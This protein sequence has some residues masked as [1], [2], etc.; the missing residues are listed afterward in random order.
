MHFYAR[1]R[2]AHAFTLIELLTVIAIVGILAA[3]LIPVVSRVRA[4]ARA[5]EC[6]SNLRQLSSAATLYAQDNRGRLPTNYDGTLDGMW[7]TA[8]S[9]YVSDQK[10]QPGNWG[11][12]MRIVSTPGPFRCPSADPNDT[13]YSNAWVSYKMNSQLQDKPVGGPLPV[14]G[15]SL[16]NIRHPS[17]TL[18]FAEGRSHSAFWTWDAGDVNR[19]LWYPHS[20]KCNVAFVDGHVVRRSSAELQSQWTA[21]WMP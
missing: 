11:Q 6:V 5:T 2:R 4:S 19:G 21:L 18:M 13:A 14:R 3:I 1:P 16:N 7:F 12:L 20:S 8:L 17:N 9:R 10:V 15:L